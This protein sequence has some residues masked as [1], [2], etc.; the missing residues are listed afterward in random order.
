[1]CGARQGEVSCCTKATGGP[2]DVWGQAGRGELLYQSNW[3]S[4]RCVG[5]GRAR[6]AAV[7]KQLV[8]HQM[9]GARQ[10]EV[11][12]CTKAT[13]GPPDVWGQA[14]R[15][16]LLYQSNW[17]STRC[18]GPGRARWAAVPKQPVV[19]Q[20]CGARQGEVS[21]CTKATGGP[22]DVWGQAGRGELLYQSNWWSTRCVGPGRARWAAVPKQ[23]VVHQMC[24]ARQGEV[25]CCTKATGGPPDVWGQAGRGELLYQSNWWS[26][27]CVGPGRARWAAVPKQL[28]VHQMCGARQGEVSCCTKATGGPPDVW[29]Q[30]GRGELLYQSNWWSTRCVGPGRA[31]WAAVPK[32]LVV[33]Q[34]CGARQGEVSCCTKATGGPP[35]VWGQAGRGELLYQ[36]NWWSTRCVGPGRAGQGNSLGEEV[37]RVSLLQRQHLYEEQVHVGLSICHLWTQET[38]TTHGRTPYTARKSLSFNFLSNRPQCVRV[39]DIKSPVI[40]SNTGAPQ[41]CVLSPFLYTLYTND[42]RSVDPSTQYVRFSDDTAM[43]ALLSDFASYQ[44]YVSSVVRFSSWC[45]NNFLHLNVSKTKEMCIDFRRNRTV[46]SPIVING[47]LVEQVD[48]FKYLGVILDE[49]LSFTKHVTAVQKKSQ[50]RLHVLRKL[51]A[52]YVDPLLLLHL[53]RS[54]I[55][56]LITYCSICYYPALSVKNHNRLLKISH[57]SA[58]IIG[59]PTPMLSEIIDHAILKKARAVATESYHPLSTFFHVLPSRRRYRCIK[60]KTSRYSRSF[61][62]VAIRMLNAKWV[63]LLSTGWTVLIVDTT[64]THLHFVVTIPYIVDRELYNAYPF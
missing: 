34:M 30:A 33:H 9:C 55:E 53:Y 15:G 1:M 45:S 56:P 32:Q 36:S 49:K 27:R 29:G 16:E 61:V 44:S 52:F 51:R 25:S 38:L 13:G 48:S 8:V 63:I 22:P 39:G 54:I 23:L 28:V 46:N 31:R 6:W 62:P 20:M 24:G 35:D 43:L 10:G 2:P 19:H 26:T 42:C 5:P 3:W 37:D 47:E 58:K 59:L 11:S 4:T 17:W 50:Q 21:C 12:C 14:G 41:G 7:P 64:G 40:V 60:C 57:V 18:V